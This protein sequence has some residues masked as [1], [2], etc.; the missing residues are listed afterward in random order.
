MKK[1]LAVT[2]IALT[3]GATAAYIRWVRPRQIRWGATDEEAARPLPYDNLVPDPTWS[4]TRVVT[5]DAT[6]E[7]IW[8]WL[9]QM[10]WGR[11]GWYGYDLVDNGGRESAWEILPEHQRLEL[12][13]KFPM[14]PV[15]AMVCRAYQEPRWMLLRW[16]ETGSFLW[17][18]DPIN[19]GQT[20]LMI[21]MRDRYQWLNPLML[22]LQLAV[23]VG[24]IFFQ[25]KTLLGIKARAE[26]AARRER[27]AAAP[28]PV[29]RQPVTA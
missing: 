9:V 11:A 5:V 10:G 20:R 17:F 7:Q 22:P 14:S 21:R 4:S 23:D 16:G 19:G 27:E 6:P 12:G 18:L 28:A 3:A 25:R 26:M 24:D 2:A 15:T 1:Q 29:A 8:P 13:T